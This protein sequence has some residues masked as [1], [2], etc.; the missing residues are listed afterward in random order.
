MLRL[1]KRTDYALIAMRHLA[2]NT[3]RGW[4]SAREIAEEYHVPVELLAKVLQRLVR[5]GL[6]ASHQGI[7]GGYELARAASG[8]TVADVIEAIDGPLRVTACSELDE[9]CDQYAHCG[10]RDPLWRIKDR[11]LQALTTC[12]IQEMAS[13]SLPGEPAVQM[14]LVHRPAAPAG[15][16][17][18]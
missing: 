2:L 18:R 13:E 9:S 1:S 7:N 6:L 10:I 5:Q 8:I 3:D 12:S 11:I 15:G 14:T 16:R 17:D 4:A